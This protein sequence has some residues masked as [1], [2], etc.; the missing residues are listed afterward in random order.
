MVHI[1]LKYKDQWRRMA[2]LG[3]S[4]LICQ[5]I[6]ISYH[7]WSQEYMTDISHF[8]MTVLNENVYL[9]SFFNELCSYG[10]KL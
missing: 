2:S 3:H 5:R 10:L 6:Y 8:Q 4:E 1:I 9:E 7:Q